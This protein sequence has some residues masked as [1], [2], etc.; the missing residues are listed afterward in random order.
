[1]RNRS[2]LS[3]NLQPSDLRSIYYRT[4]G[5]RDG[6]QKLLRLHV[7]ELKNHYHSG[8]PRREAA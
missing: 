5:E 6:F 2:A 1:M 3:F 8:L 4:N 7:R